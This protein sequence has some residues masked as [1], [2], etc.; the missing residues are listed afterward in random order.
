MGVL[1]D[2]RPMLANYEIHCDDNWLTHRVQ[3]ERTI[4]NDAKTLSLSVESRGLW[5]SAGQE[6]P[7]LRGCLDVDLAVTPA[8]N[9]LAIRRLGLGIGKSESV[10]AAWVKFP[11][12][13]IQPL[14]QRYTRLAQDTYR[15]ESN[16][17]FSAE[18]TV[19]DLGLVTAYPGGWERIASW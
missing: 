14:S 1:K 13:E 19:D 7:A 4:G 10:I 5:R 6:L 3:V 9:T 2:Q 17:G 8:T 12:L 11:E 16:T 18:I 15:D